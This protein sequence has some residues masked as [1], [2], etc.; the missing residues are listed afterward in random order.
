MCT[1]CHLQCFSTMA[2]DSVQG[3]KVFPSGCCCSPLHTHR[4]AARQSSDASVT[5]SI[6]R[7]TQSWG[8]KIK[9]YRQSIRNSRQEQLPSRSIPQ[10]HPCF[11]P[12]SRAQCSTIFLT[13]GQKQHLLLPEKKRAVSSA[14]KL[15][16]TKLTSKTLQRV[17]NST[18][19][20]IPC[21]PSWLKAPTWCSQHLQDPFLLLQNGTQIVWGTKLS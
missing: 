21:K 3:S 15:S 2:P 9:V 12:P 11:P 7:V 8:N 10:Q 13:Q 5:F 14:H 1:S 18:S 17:S 4:A 19:T 6:P 16:S 20:L